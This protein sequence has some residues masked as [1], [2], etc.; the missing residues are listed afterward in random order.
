LDAS[1]SRGFRIL[2]GENQN[3]P[4]IQGVPINMGVGCI[5]VQRFQN[6]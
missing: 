6:T 2:K 3:M 5:K 4:I 1:K